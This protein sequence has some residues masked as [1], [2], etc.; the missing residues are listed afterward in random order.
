MSVLSLMSLVLT[1]LFWM[2]APVI[3]TAAYD[4]PPTATTK[5]R[6]EATAAYLPLVNSFMKAPE[7]RLTC[8]LTRGIGGQ[9][10]GGYRQIPAKAKRLVASAG[11]ACL[12]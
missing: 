9:E 8:R 10:G 7:F 3:L 5:A 11:K 4:V 12:T 6:V 2:L 1:V